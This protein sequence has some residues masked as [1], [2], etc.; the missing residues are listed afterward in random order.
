M[1]DNGFRSW[2]VDNKACESLILEESHI[3]ILNPLDESVLGWLPHATEGD[4][5]DAVKSSEK[6]FD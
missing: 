4:L 5:N 2:E 6:G 1:K 3:C